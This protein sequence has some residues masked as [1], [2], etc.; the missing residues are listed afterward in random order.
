[1]AQAGGPMA[2]MAGQHLAQAQKRSI[3]SPDA[4]RNLTQWTAL[5]ATERR[6]D[7][8]THSAL[9]DLRRAGMESHRELSGF[10]VNVDVERRAMATLTKTLMPLLMMTIIMYA[11]LH[12]PRGLV[13]EK[14]MVA[15]TAALSG[16]VLRT[17]INSQLGGIGYTV[18][19]EYAFYVFFGLSTLC[20]VSV[21]V[22]ERLRVVGNNAVAVRTEYWTYMVFLIAV[23][24]LVV[25]AI[26]MFLSESRGG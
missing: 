15:I 4:F 24:L 22:A 9:G 13:K 20:I 1:M 23:F 14:V 18:A 21:L 11:S 2:A 3:A 12:F 6:D 7:L 8:V 19:I 17:T 5:R 25:A 10:Q 26:A 16:A